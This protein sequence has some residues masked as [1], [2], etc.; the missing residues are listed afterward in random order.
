MNNNFMIK[1]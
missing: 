1:F